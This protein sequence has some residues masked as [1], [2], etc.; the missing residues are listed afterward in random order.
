MALD[1]LRSL[2]CALCALRIEGC[3]STERYTAAPCS[4]QDAGSS[5]GSCGLCLGLLEGSAPARL[6]AALR[7]TLSEVPRVEATHYKLS[8]LLPAA[9]V[10]RQQ[11]LLSHLRSASEGPG[12]DLVS[13]EKVLRWFLE[14]ELGEIGLAPVAGVAEALPLEAAIEL[15]VIGVYA[16]PVIDEL[17]CLNGDSHNSGKTRVSRK[18]RRLEA[19]L[20]KE[21][22]EAAKELAKQVTPAMV[23]QALANR[24]TEECLRVLGPDADGSSDTTLREHLARVAGEPASASFDIRRES[25]FLRG[26]YLKLSRRM[27]QSP[28]LI[29]GERKGEASVEECIAIPVGW[30]KCRSL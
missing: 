15:A 22:K 16:G 26:R 13:I 8:L 4:V 30:D 21:V 2:G 6:R 29:D 5:S 18:K 12:P 11:L 3:R 28:W 20:P 25:L 1:E 27:P 19:Y 17:E 9:F 10:F 23:L 24:T 7:A 14:E